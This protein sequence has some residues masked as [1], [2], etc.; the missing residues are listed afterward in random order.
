MRADKTE[1][2]SDSIEF[3]LHTTISAHKF[4]ANRLKPKR[5]SYNDTSCSVDRQ[6]W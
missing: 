2:K 6:G 4:T 5:G 1:I 3:G